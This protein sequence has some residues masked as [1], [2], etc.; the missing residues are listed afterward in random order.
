MADQLRTWHAKISAS[1]ENNLPRSLRSPGLAD[2]GAQ[3][4]S[5][6]RDQMRRLGLREDQL[7]KIR[8]RI[9]GAGDKFLGMIGAIHLI[10]R[11]GTP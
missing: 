3:T 5:G 11:T 4:L 8:H 1:E 7:I 10:I 6:G 9:T 2:T